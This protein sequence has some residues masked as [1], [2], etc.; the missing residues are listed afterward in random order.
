MN[1]NQN[2]YT[3]SELFDLLGYFP[4]DWEVELYITDENGKRVELAPLNFHIA[5]SKER[6]VTLGGVIRKTENKPE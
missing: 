5:N 2:T 3:V 4:D 6:R 1:T